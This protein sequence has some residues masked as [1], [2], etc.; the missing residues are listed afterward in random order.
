[1][2]TTPRESDREQANNRLD[3]PPEVAAAN[4]QFANQEGIA[5]W[6]TYQIVKVVMSGD[7][8]LQERFWA[9]HPGADL[10]VRAGCVGG[11]GAVA[12]IINHQTKGAISKLLLY[13]Y[14]YSGTQFLI[15]TILAIPG[16]GIIAAAVIIIGLILFGDRVFQSAPNFSN[17][18]ET[19]KNQ[20]S[21]LEKL[22]AEL[23]KLKNELIDKQSKIDELTIKLKDSNNSSGSKQAL[24]KKIGDLNQVINELKNEIKKLNKRI[25]QEK[26]TP[27]LSAAR[28]AAYVSSDEDEDEATED[29]AAR[30]V[31][32]GQVS[33]ASSSQTIFGGQTARI[34]E[35]N[36]SSELQRDN[37][38]RS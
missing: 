28:T 19:I 37:S 23:D 26:Q 31:S 1:M 12:A 18:N 6:L 2:P 25:D 7:K 24:N 35:G 13:L 20:G 32:L 9:E 27:Q 30:S 15:R 16:L 11:A 29:S 38:P 3:V 14:Q 22:S 10:A 21:S 4:G 36:S 34:G 17:D 33:H 5:S 8:S